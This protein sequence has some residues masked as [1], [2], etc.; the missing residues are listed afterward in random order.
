MNPQQLQQVQQQLQQYSAPSGSLL[1]W[2][3]L[4]LVMGAVIATVDRRFLGG[5]YRW[6]HDAR[7]DDDHKLSQETKLGFI[8]GQSAR[9]KFGA[10]FGI[11]LAFVVWRVWFMGASSISTVLNAVPE[12]ILLA[13]GFYLAPLFENIV[14][15]LNPFFDRVDALEKQGFKVE[16]ARE[17]ATGWIRKV[18]PARAAA[19]ATSLPAESTTTPDSP[20]ADVI[21]LA[22]YRPVETGE[23]QTSSR[24]MLDRFTHGEPLQGGNSGTGTGNK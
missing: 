19:P 21:D 16:G 13:V 2:I 8:Y 20:K 23:H 11:V 12:T 10:A 3:F 1:G 15:Y 14:D 17:R 6:W 4:L 22:A 7:R 24:E 18:F 9:V 5:L